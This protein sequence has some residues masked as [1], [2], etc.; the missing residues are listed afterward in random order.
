MG[1]FIT[2]NRAILPCWRCAGIAGVGSARAVTMSWAPWGFVPGS[3]NI[4]HQ[5]GVE[6]RIRSLQDEHPGFLHGARRVPGGHHPRQ[7]S[8]ALRTRGNREC[9]TVYTLVVKHK[10]LEYAWGPSSPMMSGAT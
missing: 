10:L 6:E 3:R 7:G 5:G 2:K 1:S 4:I 8:G 9:L